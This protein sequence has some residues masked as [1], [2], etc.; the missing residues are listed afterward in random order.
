MDKLESVK[1][2]FVHCS[3]SRFGD[4]DEIDRWHREGA[5]P[6]EMIGYHLVILNGCRRAE[7]APGGAGFVHPYEEKDD[8]LVEYGRP[9]E[10]QGAQVRGQNQNSLGVCLI[11]TRHFT[12]KQILVSLPMVL[13]NLCARYDLTVND[14]RGH[15][16]ADKG[17]T[18][19]NIDMS[20]YREFLKMMFERRASFK[21]HLNSIY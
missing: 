17:K 8:G 7:R 1:Q 5:D 13:F 9:F 18:C 19:P 3:A 6:F 16:E 15:Y 21:W 11:G 2:I 14:I 20:E 12:S 10:F 4:R